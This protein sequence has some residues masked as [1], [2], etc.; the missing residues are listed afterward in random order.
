MTNL[1]LFFALL[2]VSSLV[3]SVAALIQGKRH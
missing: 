3:L 1:D 2:G